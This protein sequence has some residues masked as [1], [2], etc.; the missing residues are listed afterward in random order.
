MRNGS[1]PNI[2]DDTRARARKF[3]ESANA[4][5]SSVTASSPTKKTPIVTKKM[6]ADSGYDNLR[7]YLNAQRGLT[8]RKDFDPT[9]VDIPD[10]AALAAADAID[11]GADP[12]YGLGK[13]ASKATPKTVEP[14]VKKSEEPPVQTSQFAVSDTRKQKRPKNLTDLL[15]ITTPYKSG[16]SVSSRADGIAQRGKTKCRFV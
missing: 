12:K 16:G 4:P 14:E 11:P 6:L 10:R 1:N 2:D 13:F 9:D 7:D 5:K 8:R 3:V 15:G